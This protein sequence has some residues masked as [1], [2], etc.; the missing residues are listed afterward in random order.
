MTC[1]TSPFLVLL[2]IPYST[3]HAASPMTLVAK[4]MRW[5]RRWLGSILYLLGMLSWHLKSHRLH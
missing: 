1:C 4:E 5:I 3:F 2:T